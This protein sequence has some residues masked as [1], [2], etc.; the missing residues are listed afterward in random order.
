[1]MRGERGLERSISEEDVT[2]IQD[3]DDSG[4]YQKG[5]PETIEQ[6]R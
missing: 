2:E 6:A 3:K 5:S 4:C 1:M